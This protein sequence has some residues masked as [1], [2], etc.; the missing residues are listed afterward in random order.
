M[1]PLKLEDVIPAKP[2]FTLRKTGKT[3]RLRLVGA[4]DHV[5]MSQ[6]GSQQEVN[7]IFEKR[8][9]NQLARIV[10][11]FLE[12]RSDFPATTIKGLDDNGEPQEVRVSGP[13]MLARSICG[14]DEE[15]YVIGAVARAFAA[16]NPLV[17]KLLE[18]EIQKKSLSL[19]LPAGEK[20]STSSLQS[21]A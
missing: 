8:E 2:E 18:K 12:D 19:D 5:W 14:I 3:H 11:Y 1:E 10:Y 15:A 16:S 9:W 21:T 13:E 7:R 6:F 17:D 4:H 20:S